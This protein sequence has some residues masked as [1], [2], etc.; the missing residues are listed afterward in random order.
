MPHP[1]L[2]DQIPKW[3]QGQFRDGR[4]PDAGDVV[5]LRPEGLY[6]PAGDFHIDPWLPVPR[7]VIT[8][9]HGDHARLAM[10]EYHAVREGLPI[11]RWRLGEQR[12][13]Q[14]DYGEAFSLGGARVS[15]HPAGHVLGSAQVRIEVDGEVWVVSGDYKRQ[16]DPT[17]APFE[18]LRCDTFITEATFGLPVYRWPD[19][20]EVARDI[21]AWREQCGE[22]GEAAVLF[23]YALGKAQRLLAEL[24]P[25]TD[26]PALLHGTIASGVQV[27][28]DCGITML[29]TRPVSEPWSKQDYAGELVLAPPSAAGS[30]WM[31]RFKRTQHGFASGWMR[32]RGNRRRRNYDRG[33]VVSDHADWPGLVGT[34]RDT[35]ASR[36]IATHGNTDAIVRA[37]CEEGIAAEA[38]RTGYGGED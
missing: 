18:V 25:L 2:A 28:R 13:F 23:C 24:A 33:F 10:G 34:V 32:I 30:P 5:V 11:L 8:H 15:L 26:R 37:L 21:V 38:F 20:T 1:H 19:T 27:Y 12:Y 17:C 9:G 36:V 7:A 29:D 14:R 16:P 31:R 35:G 3:Q 6:C 4:A 22:R